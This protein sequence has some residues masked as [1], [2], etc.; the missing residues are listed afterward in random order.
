M[1]DHHPAF[2]FVRAH[3]IDNLK[4]ELQEYRHQATGAIHYHLAME[5][6]ENVFLVAFRTVPVD[7]TGVAHILEHTTLCGSE[8]YPV[9]DPFFLMTRRSLNS[10]MNAFTASDYTAYPFASEHKQDFNNLLD[11]YLDAVFFPLLDPLDFSQE[12]HRLEFSEPDNPE[13]AL[14]YKG[15]V[16]NE[17]K[18]DQ[19]STI[20]LLYEHIKAELFPTSTYHHNSGGDPL[21]IPDLTY[22]GLVQF[23][24]KHYH[25][26]NSIFMTA[27]D[28]SATDHQRNFEEKALSQFAETERPVEIAKEVSLTET[29]RVER[30]YPAS[31]DEQK[32]SHIVMGWKLDENTDLEAMIKCN[33]LSD[34]L[35]DTSASPLRIV[36]ENTP[37]ADAPSPLC[38]LEETN[39]EM[40]FFCGVEGADQQDADAI[41]ALILKTLQEVVE[42]GVAV[43]KIEACLHQI[44]LSQREI[45]G[46]GYPYGLQ[47]MFSCLAAAVHRSDPA[48]LLDLDPVILKLREEITDPQ[49]IPDLVKKYLLDNPHRVRLT[50]YP[51]PTFSDSRDKALVTKLETIKQSMTDDDKQQLVQLSKT[52]ADRQ[53]REEPVDVLPKVG[54]SDIGPRKEPADGKKFELKSGRKLTTYTTGTNGVIYEQLITDLPALSARQGL[55]LQL[56]SQVVSE[57]GSGGRDY[58]ETQHLQHSLTGGL[59]CYSSIRGTLSDPAQLEGRFVLSSRGLKRNLQSMNQI[60]ADTLQSPALHERHRIRDLVQQSRVR[61]QSSVLNNGHGLMMTAAG[62]YFRPVPGLNHQ[63]SGLAGTQLLNELTLDSDNDLDAFLE[64]LSQIQSAL[65]DQSQQLLLISDDQ[66]LPIHDLDAAWLPVGQ[67]LSKIVAPDYQ[68][69]RQQAWVTTT[70]VNFCAEAFATVPE[71]HDDSPALTVLAG[72]LR[73]G[74]LHT[75]IREQGGAY[76]GGASHDASNGLFRFYSY[77][78][79]NLVETLDA[80]KASIDWVLSSDIPF[81]HIEQSI[82]GIVSSLD[83]PGSPAGEVRQAFHQSLFGRTNE[84]RARFRERILKTSVEDIKRVAE[85]YLTKSSSQAVLTQNPQSLVSSFEINK[86]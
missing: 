54:L 31:L 15:V 43:E 18:G 75:A 29:R 45:G 70:E 60:L 64:E 56:F 10:F 74:F 24:K 26:S 44:E 30:P 48:S 71:D 41:E 50:L 79:P 20:S 23:H 83:A 55:T 78:D 33:L 49:F 25:P 62:A 8:K 34:V 21:E 69:S 51:D 38:G 46:D 16:Y 81:D 68:V 22:D 3:A 61:R 12:G 36:L 73:N 52:L 63:A 13:T 35:L 17:M 66:D 59:G 1:T 84:H 19:S 53:S 47:L 32:K 11:I 40:S 37:L 7:S 65:L 39:L 6:A 67:S 77:R 86:I 42:E 57:I 9:R 5:H 76:G 82:L 2:E 14:V 72:V 58:L 85:L 28:I 80:F 4:L 27:G